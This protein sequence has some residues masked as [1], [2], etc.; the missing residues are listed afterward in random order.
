MIL[1]VDNYDSFVFNLARY[2]QRLGQD[3]HVVR[4]DSVDLNQL[5]SREYQ[6][7]VLSPGPCR[8]A[9]AGCCLELLKSAPDD[10]PILGVC[11]GHQAIAEAFGGQTVRAAEPMHGRT[12]NIFHTGQG[13]FS[14]CPTPFVAG[15]YHSLIVEPE[16]LPAC[17]LRTAETQEGVIMALQHRTRPIFG[18]QFHPESILTQH[19]YRL[20]ANFLRLAGMA[21]LDPASLGSETPPTSI[22]SLPN[23]P[24]TF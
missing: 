22:R 14:G 4:N 19:G 10:L 12:S 21:A 11:L 3:T 23:L 24:V 18:V 9:E 8:P 6:A 2:F 17:L 16:S 7:V 1:V 13:L 15:R 20:L 5:H